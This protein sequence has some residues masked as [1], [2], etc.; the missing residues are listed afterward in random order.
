MS[1]SSHRST[2]L[3]GALTTAFAGDRAYVAPNAILLADRGDLAIAAG[4]TLG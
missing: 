3:I 1:K 4:L 2:H